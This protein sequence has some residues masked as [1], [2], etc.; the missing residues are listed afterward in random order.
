[1]GLALNQACW[2]S[3][4]LTWVEPAISEWRYLPSGSAGGSREVPV[5]REGEW[6]AHCPWEPSTAAP[7]QSMAGLW[8]GAGGTQASQSGCPNGPDAFS[9][10]SFFIKENGRPSW[11]QHDAVKCRL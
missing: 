7:L 11:G 8:L 1:M 4:P 10:P 2:F 5:H 3:G 6:S 9:H